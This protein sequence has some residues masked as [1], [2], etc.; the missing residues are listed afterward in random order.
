MPRGKFLR[1]LERVTII[2]GEPLGPR[3][4]EQQRQGDQPQDGI[5]RARCD[6]VAE[7]GERS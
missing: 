2:F 7:L 4:L 1:R 6:R 3:D 5:A